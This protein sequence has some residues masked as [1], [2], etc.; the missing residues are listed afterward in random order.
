M[1]KCIFFFLISVVLYSCNGYNKKLVGKWEMVPKTHAKSNGS[2]TLE[3]MDDMTYRERFHATFDV[4][5]VDCEIN[6]NSQGK[7]KQSGDSLFFNGHS[8]TESSFTKYKMEE[9]ERKKYRIKSCLD[10]ELVLSN[11]SI[12]DVEFFKIH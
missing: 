11:D 2:A 9:G 4:A 3:I 5:G 8:V 7:W 6:I 10:D 1:K 12:G